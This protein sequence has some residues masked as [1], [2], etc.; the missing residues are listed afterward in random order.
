MEQEEYLALEANAAPY[1]EMIYKK[2]KQKSLKRSMIC[3]LLFTIVTLSIFSAQTLAYFTDEATSD[4]NQI[5]SGNL[6][7]EIV[8][9]QGVGSTESSLTEPIRILPATSVSKTLTVKNTGSL[10]VYIRI[11]LEKTINKSE[12]EMPERWR[13]L[14]TC[15]IMLDD[16]GTADAVEGPWVYRDGYYYYTS[17]VAA[18]AATEPL[19]DIVSFSPNM[20]NEF[21]SS[22]I[23][24][25]LVCQATQANTNASSALTAT[26]WPPE[27]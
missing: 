27:P 9:M 16:E 12:N 5:V 6:D 13:D 25:S 19:F 4:Q 18:G 7:T 23:R 1:T 26:G 10:S 3:M 20:G 22:E 24:L 2:K 11:K 17:A 14:I 8:Q 15:N 21:A